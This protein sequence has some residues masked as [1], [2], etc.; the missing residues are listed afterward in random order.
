MTAHL[1]AH[2]GIYREQSRIYKCP[3]CDQ[4]FQRKLKL[5]E[6]LTRQHNTVVDSALLKSSERKLLKKDSIPES[7]DYEMLNDIK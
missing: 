1:K 2:Q 5:Q 7:I 3:F 4:V 6:H